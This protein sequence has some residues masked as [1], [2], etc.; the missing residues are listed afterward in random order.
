MRRSI[1]EPVPVQV[2]QRAPDGP[3]VALGDGAV[4][5]EF[6][7]IVRTQAEKLGKKFKQPQLGRIVAGQIGVCRERV[8]A[9]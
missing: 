8:P 2:R 4:P 6:G 5:Q 9:S 7:G 3:S 1:E